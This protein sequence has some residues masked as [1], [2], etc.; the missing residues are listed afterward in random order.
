MADLEEGIGWYWLSRR[1][2]NTLRPSMS[3]EADVAIVVE[4]V[5]HL[6]TYTVEGREML[7]HT[8]NLLLVSRPYIRT[9]HGPYI[10]TSHSPYIRTSLY[11]SPYIRTSHSPYIRQA[12]TTVHTLGQ[13]YTTVHTL[14][15]P[16][17]QSIH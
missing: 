8:L 1:K 5:Q 16:I 10:R 7:S 4:P 9:S 11:H 3:N 14:D 12:Y 17:P 13:A 6:H 15:K 2:S